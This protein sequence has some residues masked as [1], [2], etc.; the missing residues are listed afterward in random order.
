MKKIL[1]T[2]EKIN[3]L[4]NFDFTEPLG[5]PSYINFIGEY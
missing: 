2:N 1:D 5:E 3:T 4:G